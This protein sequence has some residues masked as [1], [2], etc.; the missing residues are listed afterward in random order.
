MHLPRP[1]S[2]RRIRGR[3]PMNVP[4]RS[5]LRRDFQDVERDEVR[6]HTSRNPNDKTIRSGGDS[7]RSSGARRRTGDQSH[8]ARS[9]YRRSHQLPQNGLRK[10]VEAKLGSGGFMLLMKIEQDLLMGELDRE[11]RS[12]Q[13]ALANPLIAKDGSDAAPKVCW[14]TPRRI[15]VLENERDGSA[16]VLFDSP[17]SLMG[18]FGS[19]AARKIG[20]SL[21]QRL[22]KP[23]EEVIQ[24]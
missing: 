11:H 2:E 6:P 18:S 20:N 23:A 1:Y 3:S 12:V 9:R 13:F 16:R 24:I 22:I 8:D 21:D 14:Y 10:Q 19:A 4:C 17:E 15:A 5:S 7:D